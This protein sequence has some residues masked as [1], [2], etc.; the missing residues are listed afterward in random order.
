METALSLRIGD[1]PAA[2]ENRATRLCRQAVE[3]I[4]RRFNFSLRYAIVVVCEVE[5]G[6]ARRARCVNG[7]RKILCGA[8]RARKTPIN[9]AFS[10]RTLLA[11]MGRNADAGTK[12]T[13]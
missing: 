4:G 6:G 10:P 2:A 1:R 8:R 9:Q 12:I 13:E 7:A 3:S 5:R 11:G